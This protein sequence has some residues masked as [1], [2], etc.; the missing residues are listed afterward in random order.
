MNEIVREAPEKPSEGRFSALRRALSL[1]LIPISYMYLEA[2]LAKLCAL[3]PENYRLGGSLLAAFAFGMLCNT[4]AFAFRRKWAGFAAAFLLL[5]IGCFY[6]CVQFFVSNSY[7]TF[8]DPLTLFQGAGGVVDE[9][10]EDLSRLIREGMGYIAAF[11]APV[12]LLLICAKFWDFRRGKGAWMP[13]AALLC[14]VF[15]QSMAMGSFAMDASGAAKYT[16][17]YAFSDGIRCF[18]LLTSTERDLV[19]A[20]TG[21]PQKKTAKARKGEPAFSGSGSGEAPAFFGSNKLDIDFAQLAEE[22]PDPAIAS[23]HS[24]VAEQK[25]S[26]KNEYTGLMEGKNLVVICA[27]S[28]AG[29]AISEELT[30]TLYRM[31]TKGIVFEDYYQPFWGGSTTSGEFAVLTGLVP[32]NH[33]NSMQQ[34]IGHNNATCVGRYLMPQGYTCL[35]YHNGDFDYYNRYLTHPWLGFTHFIS[36]GTGMEDYLTDMWPPSDTEMM[37]ATVGDWIDEDKFYVYYMTYSGH[38]IY[39]FTHHEQAIKHKDLV[40][41]LNASTK[42]KSYIAAQL[43]LEDA[44]KIVFDRLEKAGLLDDT[45]IVLTSDHYPYA[46]QNSMIWANDRDYVSELYGYP[47]SNEALRDHN[48]LIMWSGAIEKLEESIV[49]KQPICSI[50]IAPTVLNL[51]G[52]DFDSRLFAG[53]DVLSTDE[54]LAL[55]NSYSWK[56]EKGFYDAVYGRFTPA[57]GETANE[58]YIDEMK[59]LV[60]EKLAYCREVLATD[61]FAYVFR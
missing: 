8:M 18:G 59:E 2:L 50:D 56:T 6:F 55:W 51:M 37:A 60:R 11:H 48:A 16:Y 26:L 61:Y 40:E 49:V 5:E 52:A 58:A 54:G 22:E 12:L 43:E 24:Y 19:Y 42:I 30:P 44:V 45:L 21:V 28:F 53:R 38:S 17:E 27:E 32:V 33:A 41:G 15:L 29:E 39:N 3:D 57:E 4:C 25:P 20:V 47:A 10:G 14:G 13:A 31:A 34:I 23:I 36:N 46:L 35:A 9:F 1:F 7:Q